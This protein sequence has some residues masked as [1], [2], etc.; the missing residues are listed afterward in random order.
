MFHKRVLLLTDNL[1]HVGLRDFY[2]AALVT[3]PPVI[4][5]KE[6]NYELPVEVVESVHRSQLDLTGRTINAH[7]DCYQGQDW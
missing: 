5:D 6:I 2:V 1:S 4:F 3:V 7:D